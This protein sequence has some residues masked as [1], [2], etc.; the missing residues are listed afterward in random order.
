MKPLLIFH[1]RTKISTK[2][3]ENGWAETRPSKMMQIKRSEHSEFQLRRSCRGRDSFPFAF[4]STRPL[5]TSPRLFSSPRLSFLPSSSLRGKQWRPL[6]NFSRWLA[7]FVRRYGIFPLRFSNRSSILNPSDSS[8]LLFLPNS[9]RL[10][11]SDSSALPTATCFPLC[12]RTVCAWAVDS[13]AR[14]GKRERERKREGGR[15]RESERMQKTKK[16]TGMD[17]FYSGNAR[18]NMNMH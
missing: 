7:L 2:S 12:T 5:F 4:S 3:D 17:F 11:S 15:G 8:V 16:K 18:W 1:D 6:I 14:M 10:S 9:L 13:A